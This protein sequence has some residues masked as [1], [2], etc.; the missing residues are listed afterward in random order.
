MAV[1]IETGLATVGANQVNGSFPSGTVQATAIN[2][3]TGDTTL[4]ATDPAA[5]T[6]YVMLSADDYRNLVAPSYFASMSTDTAGE[7][8]LAC[9]VVWTAGAA[10]RLI[11]QSIPKGTSYEDS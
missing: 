9:A 1:C 11:L 3:T 8:V 5:C 6:G 7:I 2:P 4:A 10:M